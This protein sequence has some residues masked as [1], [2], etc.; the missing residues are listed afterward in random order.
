MNA[1]RSAPLAAEIK[2]GAPS[3]VAPSSV[4]IV[5]RPTASRCCP[6][7]KRNHSASV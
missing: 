7:G 1:A 6:L 4:A 2:G 5:T 3:E